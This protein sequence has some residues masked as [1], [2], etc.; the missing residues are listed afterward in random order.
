MLR[1]VA[2]RMPKY[3]RRTHRR[4]PG[5]IARRCGPVFLE[6]GLMRYAIVRQVI[7]AFF[8]PTGT[9]MTV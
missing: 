1:D 4:R 7:G 5:W 2:K 8:A 9:T 3:P 6:G